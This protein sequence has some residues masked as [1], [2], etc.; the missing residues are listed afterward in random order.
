LPKEGP[1]DP[2]TEGLRR[3]YARLAAEWKA[4]AEMGK[5][6]AKAAFLA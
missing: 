6:P 2:A 4:L 3:S 5:T 1:Q